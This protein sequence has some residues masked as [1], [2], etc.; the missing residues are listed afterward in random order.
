MWAQIESNRRRSAVLIVLLAAVLGG[1]GAAIGYLF[2]PNGSAAFIG[3]GVALIVWAVMLMTSLAGGEKILLATAG[4]REV[5]AEEL[6]QLHN[7][8]EEMQIASGLSV[9]PKVYLM[10]TLSPNAFAVGLKPER[11]AVA[12]TSGLMGRLNRDELQAVIAHEIAHLKNR[13]SMFMTLAGG[14][15]GAVVIIADIFLRGVLYGGGRSRSSKDNQGQAILMVVALVLA[16]LAPVLAQLLYFACSRRREYLADACAAQYTR[17]PEALASALEKIAKGQTT[18][19]NTSRA[20][21]P[22]FIVPPRAAFGRGGLFST[23]PP[24]E[25]R[26]RILRSMGGMASI[27]AYEQAYQSIHK[28]KGVIGSS[29][30]ADSVDTASRPASALAGPPPIRAMREARDAAHRAQGF[31]PIDCSCGVRL[32]VPP[33]WTESQARCP[34]CGTHHP[35]QR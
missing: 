34:R 15:V 20:L 16:I 6:P 1:L 18:P 14:T 25:D 11:S 10:D 29:N 3:V 35:V 31:K 4:A 9:K 27:A 23:H 19:L 13:D 2:S 24:A 33:D 22:L 17:Y 12:V 28:G 26:I 21:T 30:M 32:K 7:L 5:S 8:V